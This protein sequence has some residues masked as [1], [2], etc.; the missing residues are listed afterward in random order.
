M[1]FNRIPPDTRVHKVPEGAIVPH[2]FGWEHLVYLA[3][4]LIIAAGTLVLI[5]YKVKKERTVDI[6][7]KCVGGVLLATV[8]A[9][10]IT[11]I[12]YY[13]T[14]MALIPN[15]FCGTTSVV[16]GICALLCKRGKLVFNYLVYAGFWGGIIVTLYPNFVAQDVS[17][18][19]PPTVTGLLHHG[20]SLYLSVLMLMTGFF[21]PSLKKFYVYPIGFCLIMCYG[22]FIMD[23]LD[24]KESMYIFA[25]LVPG[26]ILT[27][28]VV[29]PA[30]V[31]ASLGLVALYEKVILPKLNKNNEPSAV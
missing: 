20:I 31:L 19:Y 16:F 14:A 26:T 23:A 11:L 13:G 5:H 15:T 29:G 21:Q 9:N 24:I 8:I 1:M 6:I 4:F 25:P 7:V 10:R 22:V 12:E 2:V 3:I 18:M 28:Y 27:W 30:L 17:F